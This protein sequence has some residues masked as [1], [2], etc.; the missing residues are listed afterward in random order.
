MPS[1]QRSQ[2]GHGAEQRS[3]HGRAA[4]SGDKET[5]HARAGIRQ[6]LD[7]PQH[8]PD[9]SSPKAPA[10]G[11]CKPLARTEAG[12]AQEPRLQREAAPT[13]PLLTSTFKLT[14]NR[15]DS[16][17]RVRAK[18]SPMLPLWFKAKVLPAVE[19]HLGLMR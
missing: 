15:N 19:I 17:M 1:G 14:L 16:P 18:F 5:G 13:F 7:G 2:I 11:L 10:T 3:R 9:Y 4:R 8:A 12:A 6:P